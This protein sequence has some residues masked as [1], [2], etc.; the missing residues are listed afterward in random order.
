LHYSC[1]GLVDELLYDSHGSVKVECDLSETMSDDFEE[2]MDEDGLPPLRV[3]VNCDDVSLDK[4]N[5][6]DSHGSIAT[7]QMAA[8]HDL[9]RQLE[10]KKSNIRLRFRYRGLSNDTTTLIW[11][12][13]ELKLNVVRVKGPRISSMTFR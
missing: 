11:R 9:G 12:R 3:K 7:F 1:T 5:E 8:A 6:K 10:L 4:I 2:L 13:R